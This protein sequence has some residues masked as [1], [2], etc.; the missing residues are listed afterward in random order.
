MAQAA[1]RRRAGSN[2][3]QLDADRKRN[4]SQHYGQQQPDQGRFSTRLSMMDVGQPMQGGYGGPQGGYGG[5][6]GGYGGYDGGDFG[7]P[8]GGIPE[9]QKP[10]GGGM[11]GDF[12]DEV[13]VDFCCEVLFGKF[14]FQSGSVDNQREHVL[15]LLANGK[16]R[17]GPSD[18]PGKHVADLHKKL[19]SNYVEWCEFIKVKPLNYVG[20][21]QGDLKNPFHM[22]IMLYLLIWGEAGNLRHMPEC[23]CYLYHQ[24]M[25]MLNRDFLGQEKQPEGW[26]LRQVVRPV[27]KECSNMTRK[28]KLGKHLEHV[29]VRNY[30]DINE[31]FWKKHCLNIDISQ[32]G[33]ELTNNHG[34]TYYEHRSIFTLVLSYYRIFQFN[35]M[36]LVILTVLSFAS[37]ISPSGGKFWFAQFDTLGQVVP[38]YEERDLKMAV[39]AVFFSHAA[40]ATFK[41]L[42][43]AAHGWHLLVSKEDSAS[44]SRSFSYGGALTMRLIWNGL[45]FG[46]FGLMIYEP[47]NTKKNTELLEKAQIAGIAFATPGIL[48]LVTQAFAPQVAASGALAK[49]IREG[50]TCYV[51]RKMAPPLFAQIRYMIFWFVLWSLKAFIS[52][53][54]LV[55]PL[56]MPSL[57]IYSMTNLEYGSNVVS[58][59]NLGMILALWMPVVFIF[60]YDTQIYFTAFQA[61]LGW[62]QGLSMKTGELHGI[63][64][65]TKAFRVA[66]QLFDEKI[67][68]TLAKSTDAAQD[69]G[70][71]YQSQMM[72]RFVVI[73]NEIVNSF[74]EGDLVDDKEAAILQYDIQSSGDVFEPVFLSAGKLSEALEYTVKLAKGGRGDSQ[75][76]V[77]MV[78]KD[79]LSAVRSFFTACMYVMEAL[80]GSDDAEILDALRQMENIAASGSFMSTF[81]A[82]SLIQLRAVAMEF[83]EAVMDLPDPDAQSAHMTSSRV[84]TMGVVRNFVTKMESLL[85]AIRVFARR[86]DLGNKFANSKFCSSANG[87]VYATRGLVNLFHNDT[88][89]GAATRA[90]LLMSLEKA[91]AMPRVP[92][93]QRRL[94]FFMKSLMMK[95]PQLRAIKEM[96]SFS[97]VTPFYS[98]SVLISLDELNN[99]LA[100]HPVFQKVEED[101]KNITILKYLITIHPEEW[102]NFLER[103]DVSSAEEAQANYPMEIRLWASYRGQTLARTVQGMMLYEDAIKILHWLEIGSDPNKSAEQK[104]AQLEDM[105]RLKFSYICACQV[106]GKHRAEN[107]PQA[108]DIDYLLQSYPN[109][110]VAYVDTIKEDGGNRFDTVLIKSENGEVAE[111]Y[112]YELPGD[113]V[114]GEGKPENQNN[115][116]PF[117]RGEYVQTIDMN[118]QHYFEECLKMPHLMVTADQHPSGKP[119]SIIGMRE[120]IFTGN[121]SS[122]SKFKSWQELVFVTLSQRVLADPLYVRMHY[123]HP[124]IFDKVI[125][126]PRGGVSK[127][128]KGINLSEDVFAGFNATLRGGIVTH[129]EFMQ[130]GKGRDVA[131]SQISMFEGKLANGAGEMSMSREGQ[132][133]GQ[134]MDFFRLNSMFYSHTG[135]YFATWMTIVTT[136]VYMYS[137]V[138]MALAGV[139]QD[140]VLSMNQTD[141]IRSNIKYGFDERV[142]SDLKATLNTQ[143]YIQAGTFLML[144]LICVYFGEGGLVRGMTR[145]IDMIITAGPAF[146]V[147]QV[148][149]TM[150]YFD[151]NVLH[152]GAKYQATGRGF[153]ITR[154]T[155][156]LM[157]KAY[158]SS[159]YR[160]AWELIGLCV[161][162]GIF[163]N[164]YIC[165]KDAPSG[166]DMFGYEYCKTAQGYGVQTFSVW[167]ISLLWLL[168][169][170]IFN[171]D[172]LD[173]AKTKVDIKQWAMWMFAEE[174]YK[175]DDAANT[176]GWI[177]WWKG[178]LEQLHNSNMIS[179]VTVVIRESR[180]F[181]LMFY[182]TTLETKDTKYAI[183]ALAG[184]G[185]TLVL[186]GVLHGVGL[187]MRSVRPML[188]AGIYAFV[189]VAVL[190]AYFIVM[191]QMFDKSFTFAFSL[192]IGYAAALYGINEMAKMISFPDFS[193]GSVV[194]F[195]QLAFLFDFVFCM[196]LILPLFIM[197]CIPF[198]NVIQTRM[199]YNEGFSKVMSASSQYALSLATFMGLLGGAGCGWLFSLMSTLE[200]SAS[201]ASYVVNYENVLSGNLVNGTTTYIFHGAS[202]FGSIAAGALGYFLGRRLAIVVGGMV[203][204]LG[205][206]CVC[207]NDDLRSTLLLPGVGLMGLAVGILLPSLAVYI[208]EISTR[209]MRGKTI[210]ML[211]TGFIG[212]TLLNALFSSTIKQLGWVWQA[213]AASMIIAVITPVVNVFPE[214]PYWVL[215]RKGWE[216]CESNLV[217]LRRKPDVAE[218]MRYIREEETVD[219]SGGGGSFKFIIGVLLMLVSSLS[220]GVLFAFVS[221]KATQA[222]DQSTL[223]VNSVALQLAGSLLSFFF[224]DKLDHKSILFGTLIPT[225]LCAG[226]IGFNE[227]SKFLD[228]MNNGDLYLSLIS[229]LMYFFLGLGTST[230]LWT[231]SIG[232]FTTKGRATSTTFLFFLFFIIPV[233]HV[234]MSANDSMS[235]NDYIYLY[236][237]AGISVVTLVVIIG[238]GTKRN[239]VICTK[240][241]AAAD[242]ERHRRNRS[243]S[244][245]RTPATAR[246]RNLSRARTKSSAG[247]PGPAGYNEFKSPGGRMSRVSTRVPNH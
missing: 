93:A 53:F 213:F 197:S 196:G 107:K 212:G 67:V 124:D 85:N 225:A 114:L 4:N 143:F 169:P 221:G 8:Q 55:R 61:L 88:A 214:S 44:S 226:V 173:Y 246:S 40:I 29:K 54:I 98:E 223:A 56:M 241:E 211:G 89:M 33:S 204:M 23:L 46:V 141:V 2:Y 118:Q 43:E 72:L 150:H 68:T 70:G 113:P 9:V 162:Y 82:A 153:K 11:Q 38:P 205:M 125:A 154:E 102:E 90:Y 6:Q 100:N 50:E 133:M 244:N 101:G 22:D 185:G 156:V 135:F 222:A 235:K 216:A 145:F 108:D 137:K 120:H 83:L 76:S 210:L 144:P 168:A 1:E 128:S 175:D 187:G 64:A 80:L 10:L 79:C 15:L 208:Y 66:P 170:F 19:R 172:G 132:R 111:V 152:G 47:L 224:I 104:Q 193:I 167:F 21:P 25:G 42:L 12:D 206:V 116:L 231:A 207:A 26:Y 39:I 119:V 166:D 41:C 195:E 30:D 63:R 142:F 71:S 186:L 103:V 232:M 182:V 190:V 183:F 240:A 242:K 220:S 34:K 238:A 191:W 239:G 121:A 149:T 236:A 117:T 138:Y 91:D 99:P 105:V 227:S 86:P 181:L 78:K 95:I 18:S 146:F 151:N 58:F 180:H 176:G 73:W 218:E 27:W 198:L 77:Y 199:M 229:M 217:I 161:V 247:T 69:A 159:H 188:R 177:G 202:A 122:L 115:A 234:F 35:M 163:G 123:G 65:I 84:H 157:Y 147:F 62:F 233:G 178:D 200:A 87:Y 158:S 201:F 16:A 5:P 130:C 74:R 112:R 140:M 96:H 139:Q 49:F 51:G 174:S 60:N 203:T 52:Y 194:V 75:L 110:R 230:A 245:G 17:A 14:G 3:F 127:S 243:E 134:F 13:S 192:F 165:Q 129:V 155:L 45:F 148:G 59:H 57:A 160:K 237:L 48:V 189:V 20:Q 136:F 92:E 228:D 171:S 184:A 24:M 179:R 209:D 81:D 106:Y 37:A 219:E 28:N 94:G 126:M 31:Y 97:V 36:F 215:E 7:G 131:L 164:F 32:I 109:L